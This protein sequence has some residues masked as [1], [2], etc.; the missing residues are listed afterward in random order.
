M[1]HSLRVAAVVNPAAGG[2]GDRAVAAME[3]VGTAVVEVIRTT[4]PGDATDIAYKLAVADS[5]P[6]IIAGVGGD[7]TIAEVVA[8][9]YRARGAGIHAVPPL[10]V[11]PAGTGNS[12]YRGVWNDEPWDVVARRALSG[13]AVRR[14]FDLARIEQNGHVV[15]LGSGSG[16][17]AA[18]LQATRNR[19]EKGRALLMAAALAAME[20]YRP[21][22]GR[23]TIDGEPFYEGDVV[24]TIVG[25]FRYRGGILRLVPASF[26]DDHLLDLTLVTPDADMYVF[27]QAAVAGNVYD[28]PGIRHGRGSRITVERLDGWPVLFEHDGELMPETEHSY[29]IQ[30]MPAALTAL[31]SAQALPWF[32]NG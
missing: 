28:V 18:S 30:V 2:D 4:A 9:L 11:A 6:D 20:T 24:E 3:T 27:G 14:T 10:L 23:V 7:G 1:K 29:D 12:T 32:Q 26:V 25:G 5:P 17:F 22:P 15:V 19:P 16:L 8:G 31:S 21:Y 13:G